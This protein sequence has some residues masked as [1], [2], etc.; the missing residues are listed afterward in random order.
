[1]VSSVRRSIPWM[2]FAA[3]AVVVAVGLR[4]DRTG[5]MLSVPNPPFLWRYEPV[6]DV[7]WSAVAVVVLLL[8]AVGGPRLLSAR[9]RPGVFALAA[10]VLTIA[11]RLAE[12]AAGSGTS[13]WYEVFD[14]TRSFEADN[15]YLPALPTLRYGVDIFLDR[16]SEVVTSLPVHAAGHPPGLLLLMDRLEIRTP[17]GLAALCIGAGVLA[18][19]ILYPLARR[20]LEDEGAA[21]SAALLLALSPGVTMFGVTSA[22]ALYM[23]L[24]LIAALALVAVPRVVGATLGALTLA[25]ASFFAWS[26]LAV[27]AWA[28]VLRLRRDGLRPALLLAAAC[29]VGLVA[30][31]A[32]LHAA[33]GFDPVGTLRGTEQ[34][35]RDGIARGRPYS[36]WLFGSPVAFLVT[37]GLPITWYAFRA[38]GAGRSVAVAIF[39]VLAI[40]TVLGFTKAET[41]RI[42]L[43]FAPFLCLAAAS[44]LPRRRLPLVLGLLAAQ[45]LA[46][47]LLYDSVW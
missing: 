30:F 26:L 12:S 42:W 20:L 7:W 2:A 32:V 28:A 1:M 41:E 18:T 6:V 35:Y 31:Y 9:V 29:G 36:F 8:A 27:G 16:F 38:L 17:E 23:T 44:V 34:V 14:R 22:D 37:L 13:G 11:V 46:S 40:A 47:E 19:P 43:F 21:R 45:G 25:A 15:E 5:T 33:Y 10:L 24:G 39:A 4:L 3:G